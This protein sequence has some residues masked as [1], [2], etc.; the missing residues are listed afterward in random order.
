[1]KNEQTILHIALAVCEVFGS[2]LR[3][4]CLSIIA[5][6]SDELTLWKLY[7]LYFRSVLV[8]TFIR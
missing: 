2:D 3:A 4:L 6:L 8:D 1:M 7:K 5:V